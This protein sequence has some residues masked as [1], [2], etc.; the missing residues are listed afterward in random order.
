M[1]ARRASRELAFILFSQFD[2]KITTYPK[3]TL[4][5]IILKSVR[6]LSDNASDELKL[7]MSSLV[8]IKDQI[9]TYEV[10]HETNL[11]R[12]LEA[13]NVAVPIP[14]TSDMEEKID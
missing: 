2:K 3:E 7:V 9:K 10:E 8:D 5:D 4:E 6:M 13:K 11:N 12:P 14:M 1:Q